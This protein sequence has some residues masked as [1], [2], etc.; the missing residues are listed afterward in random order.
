MQYTTLFDGQGICM[1]LGKKHRQLE[2]QTGRWSFDHIVL[3]L[4]HSLILIQAPARDAH[5]MIR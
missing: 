3:A 5:V 4:S 2:M 1:I